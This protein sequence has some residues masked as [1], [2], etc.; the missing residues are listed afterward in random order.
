LES[1]AQRPRRRSSVAA[2]ATATADDDVFKLV[3]FKIGNA[4]FDL[5]AW[6]W[7]RDFDLAGD[8]V[9][10]GMASEVVVV[11]ALDSDSV[12]VEFGIIKRLAMLLVGCGSLSPEKKARWRG[13][14][15]VCAGLLWKPC[16]GCRTGEVELPDK[17]SG[18]S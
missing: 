6:T 2:T 4:D 15:I 7:L 10:G 9:E 11:A 1:D 16:A 18:A 17:N 13:H 14:S 5:A 8:A 3:V 12:F